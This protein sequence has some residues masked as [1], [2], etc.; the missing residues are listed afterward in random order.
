MSELKTISINT[1]TNLQAVL[2]LCIECNTVKTNSNY[3]WDIWN[4]KVLKIKDGELTLIGFSVAALRTNFYIKELNVMFDAGLSSNYSP[5]TI[6]ITHLHTDHI[7]N[8]SYHFNPADKK[9]LQV[10]VPKNLKKQMELFIEA[11]HPYEGD[12]TSAGLDGAYTVLEVEP[13]QKFPIKIKEKQYFL[14][15][16]ECFHTVKCV[17]YG[18]IDIKK[19]LKKEYLGLKGQEIKKLRE[20]GFEINETVE[21]PFFLYIGDTSK[22]VLL[23]QQEQIKKYQTVMIECTFINDEDESRAN[24]TKHIH[25]NHISNFINENPT[26]I[27]ILYHFSSKYKREY[28][29]E[30]FKKLNLLNVVVWNSN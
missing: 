24:L 19:K 18:L 16:F 28:I 1:R 4:Q 17:G 21:M 20:K 8:T 23:N 29:N 27:F 12:F 9:N 13:K 11:G 22:E 7:A 6:F 30:F 5:S 25:W 15:I 10:Y 26:I 2:P 3:L 14:E